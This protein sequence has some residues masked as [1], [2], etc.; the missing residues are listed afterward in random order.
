MK[1]LHGFSAYAKPAPSCPGY[2]GCHSLA[3]YDPDA[4]R[5]CRGR[6]G[7]STAIIKAGAAAV[8]AHERGRD[9]VGKRGICRE[10]PSQY[11]VEPTAQKR[12]RL[13]G[14]LCLIPAPQ[15]GIPRSR[16][17][18]L[19]AISAR[20]T[21]TTRPMGQRASARRLSRRFSAPAK[22]AGSSSRSMASPRLA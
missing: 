19:T 11:T 2:P 14:Y 13:H 6:G 21:S 7:E 17:C 3:C 5:G 18:Y 20:S 8:A 4:C 15:P 12:H 9:P 10:A 1:G 16:L 22:T